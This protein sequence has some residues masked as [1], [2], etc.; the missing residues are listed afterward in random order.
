M[1]QMQTK[2]TVA[3]NCGAKHA[4]CIKVIGGSKKMITHVG[5]TIIVAVGGISPGSK[6]K[7]GQVM[8]GVI[9][10]TKSKISRSDGSYV[11]FGDNAIVLVGK[12]G[13]PIGTRIFGPVS[14][15]VRNKGFLK[16]ISLATEVL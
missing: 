16:I 7:K 6:L 1:I 4:T 15:E 5:D 10:R 3:D 11:S 13:E 2:L 8:R 9:V 12:D 14:R